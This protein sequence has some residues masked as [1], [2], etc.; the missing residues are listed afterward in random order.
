MSNRSRFH[1]A[2]AN[3]C[4]RRILYALLDLDEGE[5][6]SVHP[7]SDVIPAADSE[8]LRARL[9]HVHLPKLDDY[10]YV[11]WKRGTYVVERGPTFDEAEPVLVALRDLDAERPET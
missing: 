3:R 11:S 10:G 7:R 1:D 2:A 8:R 6:L 4:R 9:T 5:R